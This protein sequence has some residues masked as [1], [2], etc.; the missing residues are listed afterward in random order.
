MDNSDRLLKSEHVAEMLLLPTKTIRNGGAGT[1]E[2]PRV[3]LGRLVRFSEKAVLD[4]IQSKLGED[5]REK[6]QARLK[7]ATLLAEKRK[8]RASLQKTLT[9]ILNGAKYEK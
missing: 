7:I 3:K 1:K 4:W 9:S 5:A 6:A 2:I 8:H